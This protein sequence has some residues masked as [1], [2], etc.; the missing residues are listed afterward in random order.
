MARD[1][2]TP[3]AACFACA[4]A[5][6][7]LALFAYSVDLSRH[8]DVS[9]FARLAEHQ[10]GTAGAWADTIVPLGDLL[11]LVTMLAVACGIALL[12]GRPLDA[13]GAIVVVAGANVTTQALKFVLAHPR[14]QAAIGSDRLEPDSFPSGHATAAASIAIAFAFVVPGRWRELTLTLGAGFAL[15]M[16]GAVVVLAWHYPSDVVAGFLVAAAWGFAVLAAGR[17][18]RP[19]RARGAALSPRT[20]LPSP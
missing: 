7:L 5:L 1:L 2:R 10:H 13:L 3:L 18:I 17:A 8:V 6:C 19:R 20:P 11:A 9:M 15:A 12:R 4:A 16:G 14:A